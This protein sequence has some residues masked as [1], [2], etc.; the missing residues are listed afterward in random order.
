MNAEEADGCCLTMEALENGLN[1]LSPWN[2]S[3]TPTL[4]SVPPNP[5]RGANK[6]NH[7]V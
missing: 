6:V 5:L 4:P 7:E 1:F 2:K 3:T